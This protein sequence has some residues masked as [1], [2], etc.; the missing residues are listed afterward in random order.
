MDALLWALQV[1]ALF[2][3]SYGCHLSIANWH[4]SDEAG[5]RRE[6]GA[7]PGLP[8]LPQRSDPMADSKAAGETGLLV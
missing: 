2:A 8:V 7:V 3:L 6:F 5:L 1:L 4:L